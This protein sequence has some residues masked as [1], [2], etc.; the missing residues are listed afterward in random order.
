MAHESRGLGRGLEAL[1]SAKPRATAA[2]SDSIRQPHSLLVTLI[3][4][5]AAQP[6]KSISRESLEGLAASIKAKGVIEPIIVRPLPTGAVGA[7]GSPRR[8]LHYGIDRAA[9][10]TAQ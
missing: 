3:Q 1:L 10:L 8:G 7:P 4:A 6:R 5:G 2:A 9:C